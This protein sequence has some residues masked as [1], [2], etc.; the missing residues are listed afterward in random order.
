[1]NL[2]LFIAGAADMYCG[3]C[4][5]DNA[6]AV[7]LKR[8]GHRVTLVPLYTP[9]RTDEPSVSEDRVFF[10]GV[11]VY[12]E[13]RV[14]F[15]RRAPRWLDWLWDRPGFIRAV[16]KRSIQTEPRLLGELTVSMLRGEDGHQRKEF[17]KLL[18]WLA[19]EPRPDVVNLP[20]ALLISLAAPLKR[21]LGRPVCCTLQGEDLFLEGLAEPYR[22]EAHA[23]IRRHAEDVDIF[24]AVSDYYARFMTGYLGIPAGKIR[25][26]PLGI[27]LDGMDDSPRPPRT[28]F[29]IG[30]LARIAPEKGLD[31]L[32]A[33]Y[34]RLRH[35]GRL[36]AARLE[37]AG[38]LGPEHRRYFAGI[39]RQMRDWGLASEFSYR[40][41]LDRQE[42][43]TFLRGLD[44]FSVP[45]RYHEPKGMFL[46]E[47]MAC[48]VPVVQPRV[49]AFP[50]IINLTSGGLLVDPDSE[51]SLADGIARLADDPALA[52]RLG[53][54][55]AAGVR[56]HYS[57]AAM[58]NRVLRIYEDLAERAVPG[59]ATAAIAGTRLERGRASG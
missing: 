40:G 16:S 17:E 12:L 50:A 24:I 3:S 35:D 4:L 34:R 31:R 33:A 52:A 14:P 49:G 38:Y 54:Q 2:L 5:R 13:Q 58:A 30:Y 46:L 41:V 27:T 45:T 51:E 21:A 56:A 26:A 10:G 29:T 18:A 9:A 20:N 15:F 11:S 37:V 19:N 28:A 22:S 39:E 57:V 7:E 6:L 23:L 43:A 55:G 42:K 53:R 36:Q 32:C 25:V 59:E 48:G 47:A 8:R 44:A 1:V